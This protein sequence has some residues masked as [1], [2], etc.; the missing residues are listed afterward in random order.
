MPSYATTSLHGAALT[1]FAHAERGAPSDFLGGARTGSAEASHGWTNERDGAAPA[2][3]EA[4]TTEAG[5]RTPVSL[6]IF[7]DFV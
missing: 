1:E 2:Y 3:T 5:H 4:M 6:V 7:S